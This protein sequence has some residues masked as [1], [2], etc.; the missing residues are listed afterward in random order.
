VQVY[1]IAASVG[2]LIFHMELLPS[3]EYHQIMRHRLL[4]FLILLLPI[5]GLVG[6]AM[7]Y[8]MLPSSLHNA[9]AVHSVPAVE[10]TSAT[11][12][13]AAYAIFHWVSGSLGAA[14]GR[15]KN[16]GSTAIAPC[17]MAAGQLDATESTQSQCTSCQVCH[18]SVAA[19]GQVP[20]G[21]LQTASALPQ[22]QQALWHSA[23]PR[24]IAKT[25]VL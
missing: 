7:A 22:H 19:L 3:L 23:E 21:L 24:S 20:A 11:D 25:P 2:L 10:P 9:P 15:A 17:H 14:D 6:D 12:I 8:S 18:L 4:I 16:A 5:R 1:G 13:A